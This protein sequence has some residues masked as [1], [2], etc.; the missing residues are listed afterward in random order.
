MS[1]HNIC[2]R[3]KIRKISII[4]SRAKGGGIGVGVENLILVTYLI[5]SNQDLI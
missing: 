3:G 1:T 2:F 5:C 4:L